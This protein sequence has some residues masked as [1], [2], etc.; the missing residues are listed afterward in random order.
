ML[1]FVC[2]DISENYNRNQL[3][4][5]L[6]HFGLHRIQKSIFL[7]NLA[8]D[9]IEDMSQDMDEFLSSD[10]DSIIIIP[11]HEKSKNLIITISYE[12]I[13]IDRYMDFEIV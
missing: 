2:Y 4:K 10:N 8:L 13:L 5:H 12:D 1:L 7:G 9:E 6:R 11:L 3:I